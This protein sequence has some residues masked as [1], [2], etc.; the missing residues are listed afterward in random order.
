MVDLFEQLEQQVSIKETKKLIDNFDGDSQTL[1]DAVNKYKE[2]TGLVFN[3]CGSTTERLRSYLQ[4][5]TRFSKLKAELQQRTMIEVLDKGQSLTTAQTKLAELSND[6]IEAGNQIDENDDTRELK[7]KAAS[8]GEII[9]GKQSELKDQIRN[10]NDV[11]TD[12]RVALD[13][14]KDI[15]DINELDETLQ[16]KVKERVEKLIDL[17]QKYRDHFF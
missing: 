16:N 9:S 6:F 5:N 14:I 1:N 10:I 13:S 17:C 3:F 12:A 11:K 4:L 2:A 15:E 8:V 7:E